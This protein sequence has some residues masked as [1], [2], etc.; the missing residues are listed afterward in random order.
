MRFE[1]RG[2]SEIESSLRVESKYGRELLTQKISSAESPIEFFL[3]FQKNIYLLISWLHWV[4]VAARGIF[5]FR[6]W[7]SL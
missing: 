7:T 2:G 4:I 5:R 1:K 6:A 3:F